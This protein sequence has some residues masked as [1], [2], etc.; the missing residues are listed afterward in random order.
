MFLHYFATLV[1]ISYSF[2]SLLLAGLMTLVNTIFVTSKL[3][4]V[5]DIIFYT[6]FKYV[7]SFSISRKVFKGHTV[8]I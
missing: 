8:I 2:I 4:S 1:S 5:S 3:F 6:E 7:L